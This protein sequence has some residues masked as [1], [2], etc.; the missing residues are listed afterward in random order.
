MKIRTGI[1][2]DVHQLA[3][4]IPFFVGGIKIE[5]TKG[6]VG[7]SDADCLIH[8]ICD[9]LLGAANMRDIG[10]HFPDTDPQYKGIDSKILL[11]K[12][13]EIIRNAGYQISNVDSTIC[14]QKPKIKD[15]IP[16]MQKVLAE[17]MTLDPDDV[18][19]KATTTEH[20]GYTGREEGIAAYANVLIYK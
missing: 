17:V 10:Y 14:L 3:D 19:I 8:A 18:S 9:A 13:C 6:A 16:Q 7:H 12:T 20:L 15:Y 4:G 2:F 5:H 1:G 11:K